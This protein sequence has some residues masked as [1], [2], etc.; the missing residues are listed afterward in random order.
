[1]RIKF[2]HVT[3]NNNHS[4]SAEIPSTHYFLMEF[5]GY[6]ITHVDGKKVGGLCL[7]CHEAIFQGDTYF[8]CPLDAA[9]VC[10]LCAKDA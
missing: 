8:T 7:I 2:H 10:Q 9:M 4:I 1:M 3:L 5:P 6:I